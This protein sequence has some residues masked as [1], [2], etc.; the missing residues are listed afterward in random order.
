M[1]QVKVEYTRLD[2]DGWPETITTTAWEHDDGKLY[3]HK[4]DRDGWPLEVF[5]TDYRKVE[6]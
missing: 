6:G 4:L 1:K 2:R 5:R 3:E